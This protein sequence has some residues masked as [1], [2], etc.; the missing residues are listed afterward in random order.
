MVNEDELKVDVYRASGGSGA[1]SWAVRIT[2]VPSGIE[3]IAEGAFENG[4]NPEPAIKQP[5]ERLRT[6]IAAR[7]EDA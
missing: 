4:P 2:H 7:L 3:V 6:E 5:A 1:D